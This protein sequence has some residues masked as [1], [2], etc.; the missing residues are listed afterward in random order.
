MF[1]WGEGRGKKIW[2]GLGWEGGGSIIYYLWYIY[3][4][5]IEGDRIYNEQT[6]FIGKRFSYLLVTRLVGRGKKKGFCVYSAKTAKKILI[7][8]L[9]VNLKAHRVVRYI[10]I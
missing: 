1:G 3:K 7:K 5:P 10:Y 4:K 6:D 2:L 8:W 9:K